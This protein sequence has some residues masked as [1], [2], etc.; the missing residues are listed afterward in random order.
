MDPAQ[1]DAFICHRGPDAKQTFASFLHYTLDVQGIR[2]FF[3]H[4]MVG[5]TNPSDVME[6]AMRTASWGVVVLTPRFFESKWCM[7]ELGAFLDRGK[8]LPVTLEL[9]VDDIDA[10][11]I[12]GGCLEGVQ[13]VVW[14]KWGGELWKACD[15]EEAAWRSLVGRVA[16]EAVV[17]KSEDSNDYWGE[18]INELVTNLARKLDRLVVESRVAR[19][20]VTPPYLRNLEFLG[21]DNELAELHAT[22]L[23]PQSRVSISSMGGMGKTQLALE[24]VY[25]HLWEYWKVLWVNGSSESLITNYLGLAEDL[26][27]LLEKEKRGEAAKGGGQG[28]E[29]IACIR[30]GLERP[31]VPCLLVL[32]DVADESQLRHLL[33]RTGECRV[34]VT[35]RVNLPSYLHEIRLKELAEADRLRL[36]RGTPLL[37]PPEFEEG[38]RKLAEKFGYLTLALSVCSAWLR[39]SNLHPAELLQRIDDEELASAFRGREADPI[40]EKNPDLLAL[41]QASIEQIRRLKGT[42]A[43]RL[44]ERIIWVGGWFAGVPIRIDLLASAVLVNDLDSP[45]DNA[46]CLC[47]L[48]ALCRQGGNQDV[49]RKAKGD[50]KAAVD[51]LVKFNLADRAFVEGLQG[52]R[53]AGG[54]VLHAILRSFGRVRGG[55]ESAVSMIKSLVEEGDAASDTEHFQHACD[56]PIPPKANPRVLL[57][58]ADTEGAVNGI[59]LPLVF[60]YQRKGLYF[61]ARD[62]ISGANIDGISDEL[63]GRY[64][65]R[66]ASCL[67]A[68][69]QYAQSLPLYERALRIL[70]KALGPEHPAVANTLNNMAGLHYSQGE[71][72]EAMSLYGRA[73]SIAEKVLGP[74]HSDMATMLNNMAEPLKS[75]GK[76]EEALLIYERVRRKREEALGLE[77]S[78]V[79]TTLNNMAGLHYSQGKFEEAMPL[80]E[81]SLRINEKALGPEHP[82]VASTLSNMAYLLAS[83]GKYEEALPMY[84]R[85]LCIKE[86]AWGLEHPSVAATLNGMAN[87]LKS[88]GKYEEALP[89][90]VRSLCI[91]EKAWGLEHPSVA[92]TLNGMANLLNSQGKC[93]EALLLY[94]RSLRISEKALGPEHPDVAT[95]LGNMAGQLQKQGKYEEALPLYQRSL[96]I[97]EKAL[98]PEHPDVAIALNNMA[99]LLKSQGKYEEA[100]PLYKT[101]L[102]ILDKVLGSEHPNTAALLNNM[103]ELLRSQG[104]YEEAMPQYERALRIT[105]KVLGPE[106]P[107]VATTLNNMANLH[108]SQGKYEEALPL[109]E[110]G[111]RIRKKALG[112]EH[113]D[114][115]ATLNGMA[116]LHYSQGKYEEA[117]TLYER[118]LRINEKAL[119]PE[120]LDVATTLSSMANLLRSQGKYEEALSHYNRISEKALGLV[121]PWVATTLN[122]MAYLLVSQGKYEEPLPLYERSMA[123]YEKAL[124]PEHPWVATPL[125]NMADLLRDQGK[126]KKALPLYERFLR[127]S[128]KALGP[129][130]PD[131]AVTLNDM[132]GLLRSQG[133]YE[134]ALPLYQRA[135]SIREKA[136]GPGHPDVA[137]LA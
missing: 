95:T 32:D 123:I 25:R 53:Q 8:I 3:D 109:Y 93:E 96:R 83:Q 90:Y 87:L 66:W 63:Q 22:L 81:R 21:R 105:E 132:A 33:P 10:T 26:G 122:D 129:E 57:N 85:S 126:Y 73:V 86:K 107:D 52:G 15:M 46:C 20:T 54:M 94:K 99:G 119:G 40:F 14:K 130:H 29:E 23:K 6:A 35:T 16:R 116:G 133:K 111:L 125:K 30:G 79:A 131:V 59:L 24:Y 84:V 9:E 44:G 91:K 36:M 135:L 61:K 76:Y 98:G 112:P 128:E 62:A 71:Y 101:G 72:E 106:H 134:E 78:L 110:K 88:Q 70:E 50:I 75:Q 108:H 18:L 19:S 1:W 82:L 77:H 39:E 118:S 41:F 27:V 100:L 115:A 124:G 28:G 68:C 97:S 74:E 113:P 137:T 89:M 117:L 80:Y 13:S 17:V 11:R 102:H 5:G 121:H 65:D 42:P 31:R 38:L 103:A 34:L 69:G 55:P 58:A 45:D 12:V 49:S 127:M 67:E 2:A 136:L 47:G 43:G 51:E 60:H 7:K 4:K 104:K 48:L 92:A 114:V 37:G 56:L 120:H 64:L